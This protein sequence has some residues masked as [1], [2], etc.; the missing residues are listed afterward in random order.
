MFKILHDRQV[1]L[2]KGPGSNL[3][4]Q[5]NFTWFPKLQIDIFGHVIQHWI[6]LHWMLIIN[7]TISG[8][9]PSCIYMNVQLFRK[10]PQQKIDIF[11]NHFI[12][13]ILNHNYQKYWRKKVCNILDNNYTLLLE[14]LCIPY[15]T[16][17]LPYW[18]QN[19]QICQICQ[20]CQYYAICEKLGCLLPVHPVSILI[21]DIPRKVSFLGAFTFIVLVAQEKTLI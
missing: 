18:S 12:W 3:I 17:N 21:F 20:L 11:V 16:G 6:S 14:N 19:W 5:N 4:D 7:I 15:T 9:S 13:F 8:A 1:D 2:S 10:C